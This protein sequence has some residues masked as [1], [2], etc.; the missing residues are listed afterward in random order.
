[1]SNG[2]KFPPQHFGLQF[3]ILQVGDKNCISCFS[4]SVNSP[5]IRFETVA[6]RMA[7]ERRKTKC[8]NNEKNKIICV[9]SD[10]FDFGQL[11]DIEH[12]P[13]GAVPRSTALQDPPKNTTRH[14]PENLP[15]RD[16]FQRVHVNRATL[17]CMFLFGTAVAF[18]AAQS[19][20]ASCTISGLGFPS[21]LCMF[22]GVAWSRAV[23]R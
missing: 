9:T 1:M 20:S 11:A 3:F 23:L 2:R 14:Q 16:Y 4:V 6:V 17:C 10:I 8:G 19:A 21:S 13:E 22:V 5:G 18:L 7:R 12:V 15:W